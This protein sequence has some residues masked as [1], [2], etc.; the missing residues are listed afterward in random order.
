MN[1][2]ALRSFRSSQLEGHKAVL[3][4]LMRFST[5]CLLICPKVKSG[6]TVGK[7]AISTYAPMEGIVEKIVGAGIRRICSKDSTATTMVSS[8]DGAACDCVLCASVL[9]TSLNSF[10]R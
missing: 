7:P 1:K 8:D 4:N 6:Y 2:L 5:A 3:V 9:C 10:H